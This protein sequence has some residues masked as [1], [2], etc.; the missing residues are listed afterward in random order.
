MGAINVRPRSSYQREQ[1]LQWRTDTWHPRDEQVKILEQEVSARMRRIA[2]D[3]WT[4]L[5]ESSIRDGAE[6]PVGHE[7]LQAVE[8]MTRFIFEN[9]HTEVTVDDVAKVSGYHPNYAMAVFKR[10][11]GISIK[12]AILRHRL[13]TAQA[14]LLSSDRPISDVA[15]S[16]GF[17]SLSS[18]YA[19]FTKRFNAS[20][21]AFRSQAR[22]AIS[23]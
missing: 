8:S 10:S 6:K 15:F 16:S 18:F 21:V 9:G 12:T 11:L 22:P 5:G 19:A 2:A 4:Q 23:A 17:G 1:F 14:L 20:P 3:G 7:R 13:D